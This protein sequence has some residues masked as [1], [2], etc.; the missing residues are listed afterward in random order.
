[1][2]QDQLRREGKEVE[3]K[4]AAKETEVPKAALDPVDVYSLDMEDWGGEAKEGKKKK[5]NAK[6][7]VILQIE[8]FLII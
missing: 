6:R 4:E 3:E 2:R 5:A 7:W 1:M 8:L